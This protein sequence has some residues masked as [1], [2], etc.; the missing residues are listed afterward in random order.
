[1]AIFPSC[2][3][4]LF[5]YKLPVDYL[6]LNLDGSGS[7]ESVVGVGSVDEASWGGGVTGVT[8]GSDTVGS[9]GTDWDSACDDAV[10]G[11]G[12]WGGS[13]DDSVGGDGWGGSGVADGGG[14]HWGSVVDGLLDSDWV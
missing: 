10:G 6:S 1:L 4:P 7:D 3:C 2:K 8:V 14:G 13:A 5:P 12:G 9:D 11:V